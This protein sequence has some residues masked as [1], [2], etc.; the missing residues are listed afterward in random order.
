MNEWFVI[1]THPRQEDRAVTH[2]ERQSFS[3]YCPYLA[4]QN[5]CREVLFPGYVFMY[6]I[7]GISLGTVRSTRGVKNFV[8]FGERIATVSDELIATIKQQEK[9]LDGIPVF[10][11]GQLVA[12]Q[13]GP[14]AEYRAI[15]L[16]NHGEERS[17]V[18]L[19]LLNS[20]RKIQVSTASL[21]NA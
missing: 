17:I 8:R 21:C 13:N 9:L 6:S 20:T 4:R 16:C 3:M 12:F 5:G 18:L 15:Y 14:F 1:R 10:K 19:T 7:E 11:E 2:L